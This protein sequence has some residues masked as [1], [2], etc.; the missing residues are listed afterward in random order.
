MKTCDNWNFKLCKQEK[1][2]FMQIDRNENRQF[3]TL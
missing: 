3:N 1:K 2:A